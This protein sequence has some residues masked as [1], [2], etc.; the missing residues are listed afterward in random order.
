MPRHVIKIYIFLRI[1]IESLQSDISSSENVLTTY[2]HY[3]G[4]EDRINYENVICS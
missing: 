1:P 4:T 2:G 3:C